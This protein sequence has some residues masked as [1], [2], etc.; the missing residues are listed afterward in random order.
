MG[1]PTMQAKIKSIPIHNRTETE[2]QVF[3]EPE[4]DCI[5]VGPKQKCEI[6]PEQ[7]LDASEIELDI[8]YH[9]DSISLHL[10]AEKAV[11]IDG[12]QVR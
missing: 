10:F 11:L 7:S 2:M 1:I 4:G 12:E 8:E 6:I 9:G 3:L 5:T